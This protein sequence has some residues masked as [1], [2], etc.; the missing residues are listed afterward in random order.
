MK[1]RTGFVSNSSSSSFVVYGVEIDEDELSNNP[2][3]N[4]IVNENHKKRQE[5]YDYIDDIE[6]IEPAE[7]IQEYFNIP[8]AEVYVYGDYYSIYSLY[9][10]LSPNSQGKDETLRAF[11]TRITDNINTV[12]GTNYT[13]EDCD[14]YQECW[15]DT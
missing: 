13:E 14:Y 7:L 9:L 6:D 3:F 10:G 12:L 1:I 4:R 2:E 8:G 11:G 15:M 5:N